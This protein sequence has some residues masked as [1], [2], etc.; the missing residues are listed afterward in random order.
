M[1]IGLCLITSTIHGNRSAYD[2]ADRVAERRGE[3]VDPSYS[4]RR[5]RSVGQPSWEDRATSVLLRFLIG[6]GDDAV[7]L[8]FVSS[9]RSRAELAARL[10]RLAG[11][12]AEVKK[13]GA[14]TSGASMPLPT[15]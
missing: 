4:S 7:V 10:L 15:C 14:E 3:A 11:V 5:G 8:Q 2:K 13:A 6:Y 12:G 9:D 1:F